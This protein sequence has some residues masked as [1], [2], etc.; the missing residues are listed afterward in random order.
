[1]Q[2]AINIVGEKYHLP[3]GWLNTDFK[4]TASY[5]SVLIEKSKHYK[6]FSN[7]LDIRVIDAEYLLAMK[8]MSGRGYKNDFSDIAGILFE[9]EKAGNS[10]SLERIQ[11][12]AIELYGSWEIIPEKSRNMIN[13]FFKHHNYEQIYFKKRQEEKEKSSLLSEFK[14]K[15]PGSLRGQNIDSVIDNFKAKKESEANLNDHT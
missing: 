11:K 7:I 8:L 1:M 6:K 9:H 5:S 10:I 2:E 4:E 13:D 15:Y 3:N 12:A 14:E